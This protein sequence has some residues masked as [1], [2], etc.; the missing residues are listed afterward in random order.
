MS[1]YY[2]QNHQEYY[3]STYSLDPSLFLDVLTKYL[4]PGARILD[5]GCG[6]GRDL[7]WLK[8]QGFDPA[9][10]ERA[11]GL[12]KMARDLSGC[13][14]VEG[15][16]ET[17]DFKKT[18]YDALVLVGS[19]VHL[20]HEKL[21]GLLRRILDAIKPGGLVYLTLKKG[22]GTV[23]RE[24]GRCFYLWEKEELD[25]IFRAVNLEVLDLTVQVS[26]LR[27]EDTWLGYL[28]KKA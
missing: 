2:E 15:D 17:H 23:T 26:N 7:L 10:L 1:D 19:L 25:G 14:V 11:P 9:G 27:K 16:F 6:S 12:A 13:Q 3:D 21:K 5:I 4:T 22:K 28:L 18:E 8:K 20:H 24:D